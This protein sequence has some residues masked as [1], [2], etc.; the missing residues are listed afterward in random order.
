[1]N[2]HR[3]YTLVYIFTTFPPEVSGSAHFN[4]ERVQWFAKQGMYRIIVLAPDCQNQSSL[5]SV[6][7]D[8]QD[9]LIIETYPSKPWLL[10][11]LLHVPK[12]S[13]ADQ[14]RER[15]A[16]YKPDLITVVDIERLFWF[17]TWH[18]PGISYARKHNIPYITEYH[19]DYYGHVST[20]PAGKLAREIFLKPLNRYLYRQC[21][22]AIA[23]SAA[24][25]VGLQQIGISDF[26]TISMYGIDVYAYSPERR[27]RKCLEPWLTQREQEHKVLIFLGRLAFEK[28]LDILIEAFAKLKR[29][30]DK[31]SLL[32]VGDGPVDVVQKFKHLAESIPDIHFTGFLDGE[33]KANVMASC[34]VYCSPSPYETFGR[35][36]V[37]AMASGIPVL[38]VNSGGVCDYIIDGVNGYLVAP[39][40]VEEFANGIQKV[41]S[42]NNTGI[43]QQ[44]LLD[45]NQC[46]TDRGCEKLNNYY[47]HLLK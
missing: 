10:Y 3:I 12:F 14:I 44:A 6:P 38:T 37:E 32:I 5:P 26:H 25:S 46:S 40:D 15:L 8:L 33:I 27:N 18:L 9:S 42:N 29:T 39:N 2:S 28:R 34:D 21:D 7:A 23:V 19:T 13:A 4:W 11:K 22:L 45:A 41:L 16:H 17:S 1:M 20:Y 36:V 35:S 43:I 31:C 24:S 30:Q 47:Q